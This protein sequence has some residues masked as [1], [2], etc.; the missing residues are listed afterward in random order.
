MITFGELSVK[1]KLVAVV[2][3]TNALVLLAVGAALVVNE[4]HSQRKAAQ[5]QLVTLA[6]VISANTV[7]ALLFNDLKAA[8][9]N[10][11]VLR[12]KPTAGVAM[13]TLRPLP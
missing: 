4:T 5:A 9:Q 10:L 1:N 7:S 8:E 2:L 11:A 12:A 3:L 6:N 13:P